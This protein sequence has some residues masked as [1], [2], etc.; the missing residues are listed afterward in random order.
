MSVYLLTGGGVRKMNLPQQKA[1][2]HEVI[3]MEK[4]NA[5]L[6]EARLHAINLLEE[7]EN[8]P[9]AITA[10]RKVL[11]CYEN[12][13]RNIKPATKYGYLRHFYRDIEREAGREF[14]DVQSMLE[15]ILTGDNNA[16]NRCYERYVSLLSSDNTSIRH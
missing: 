7:I 10:I 6:N 3:R 16:F 11:R 1:T 8:K 13:L 2:H 5:D 15:S 12:L 9:R 4:F 14:S